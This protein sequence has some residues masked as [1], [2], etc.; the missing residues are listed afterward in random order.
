MIDRISRRDFIKKALAISFASSILP[1]DFLLYAQEDIPP[2]L[3]VARGEKVQAL[4][5]GL[6]AFGGIGRFVK[7]QD[8]VLLKP[9]ISFASPPSWG[10]TTS[11]E[12]IVEVARACLEAGAR[13]VII[14]DYPLRSPQVCFEKCGLKKAIAELKEV[15]VL[16]LTQERFFVETEIKNGVVLKSTKIA[17]EI[18]KADVIINIPTAKSHSATGVSMGLKGLMGL[19]W[20]RASF[21]QKVDLN[22]AIADLA[23]IIRPH[24][25]IMDASRALTSGGPGG[26]GVVK[27]LNTVVVGT[28][29]VAVDSYTVGLTKWYNKV[30]LGKNV[31]HIALAAKMGL[32][33]I[34]PTKVK[35]KEI[36]V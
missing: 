3:V 28:D 29:P 7:A 26:P 11:P 5:K 18:S 24:L 32:G 19:I 9:N 13:R 10:A 34:D 15:D 6:E 36:E 35:I 20:D 22:Q 2:D 17:R 1:K 14:A 25:T 23:T 16:L 27:T 21:H 12:I 33:E 8:R 4:R 31:K 30:F